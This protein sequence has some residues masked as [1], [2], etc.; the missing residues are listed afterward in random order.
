MTV[1]YS[2]LGVLLT[3]VTTDHVEQRNEE[4]S[5]ESCRQVPSLVKPA[6]SYLMPPSLI[7]LS[8]SLVTAA[9]SVADGLAVER[10]E[11]PAPVR[12]EN[13]RPMDRCFHGD[14]LHF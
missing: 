1:T 13:K 7:S 8:P 3:D 10:E 2:L 5:G 14:T 4:T 9:V 6:H 12:K 11:R